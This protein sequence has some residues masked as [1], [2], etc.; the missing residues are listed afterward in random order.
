MRVNSRLAKALALK[1]L[2]H[3]WRRKFI[4]EWCDEHQNTKPSA[5]VVNAFSLIGTSEFGSA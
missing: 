3:K 5:V 2:G 4:E 1:A